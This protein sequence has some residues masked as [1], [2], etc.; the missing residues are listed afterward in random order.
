MSRLRELRQRLG[1]SGA[2]L[3]RQAGVAPNTVLNAEHGRTIDRSSQRAIGEALSMLLQRAEFQRIGE[4]RGAL[5]RAELEAEA[6]Q[7]RVESVRESLA[8]VEATYQETI[9]AT[10]EE[11]AA[12]WAETHVGDEVEGE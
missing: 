3:A 6:A 10:A 9:R 2:E 11:V 1:I 5:V 12:L 4:A 8:E 7:R